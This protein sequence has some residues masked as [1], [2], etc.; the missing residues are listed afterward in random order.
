MS[1]DKLYELCEN[2]THRSSVKTMIKR[3]LAKC[4]Q[5]KNTKN[6]TDHVEC[7]VVR[8]EVWGGRVGVRWPVATAGRPWGEWR[9]GTHWS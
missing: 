3:L 8:R 9:W 5:L 4:E 1:E 7:P 6:N 2:T